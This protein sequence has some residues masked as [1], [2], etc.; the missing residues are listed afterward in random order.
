MVQ[1]RFDALSFVF[2]VLFVVAGLL[3]LAGG[4]D[5]VPMEWA[6]PLVALLL[7]LVIVLAARA[8]RPGADDPEPPL[9]E[10]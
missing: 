5:A 7:G 2:G 8:R 3:L 6:G 4:P 10:A 9:G 1:H